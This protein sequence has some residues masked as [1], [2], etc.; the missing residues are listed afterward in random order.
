ML[1]RFS[2]TCLLTLLLA[3]PAWADSLVDLTAAEREWLKSHPVIRLGVD[4]KWPPFEYIERGRYKGLGADYTRLISDRLGIRMEVVPDLTWSQVL[5]GSRFG[6]VDVLPAAMKTKERTRFLN[7]TEPYLNFPM[8]IISRQDQRGGR[9]LDELS[10]KKVGVVKN[11]VSHELLQTKHRSLKLVPVTTLTE[12]LEALAL[13]KVEFFVGNLASVSHA[14]QSL[15]LTN[16][17]ISGDT[18]YSFQLGMAVRDDWPE[19]ASILQKTL[20]GISDQEHRQIQKNWFTLPTAA[21]QKFRSYLKLLLVFLAVGILAFLLALVWIK[22][23]NREV[24]AIEQAENALRNSQARLLDSQR[25]AH[26]GSWELSLCDQTMFWTDEIYRILGTQ[27]G[28][29]QQTFDDLLG[30]VHPKDREQL[31]RKLAEISERGG[32]LAVQYRIVQPGG[33]LRYVELQGRKLEDGEGLTGTMQDITER[34]RIE[35]FFR[36]L[37]EEVA[38]NTGDKYFDAMAEFLARSFNCAYAMI[39]TLDLKDPGQVNTLTVFGKGRKLDNFSY[40]LDKT[41][42]AHVVS[43]RVCIYPDNVQMLFPQDEMLEELGIVSYAGI[44]LY[45]TADNCMGL[46]VLLDEK[47]MPETESMRS[48]LQISASRIG[49]EIQRQRLEKQL[50][51]TA[52]VFENTRE[53]ILIMDAERKIVTVNQG[54]IDAT[55][56]SAEEVI[57]REPREMFGA[58]HQDDSFYDMM[59][60][61]VDCSGHWHDEVWNRRKTGEVFPC[62]QSIESVKDKDGEVSQ[63][64][65]VF[66][67]ITEQKRSEERVQYLAHYDVLTDLPNRILFNDRLNHAIERASRQKHSLGVLFIDLDRFKYVNDTLGHQQGDELLKKVAERLNKSVRQIDTVAR[68]G[69]DEFTVILEEVERPEVLVTVAE[70]ILHSLNCAIDLDGHQVVVGCSI[71]LSLY[72][73]DGGCAEQLLKH[74]DTA[75]YYA[76]ENGRNTYAFYSPELSRSSYEHFRLENELRH[77]VE[78][79]H[80]LL[81]YQPQQDIGTSGITTVEALVRWQPP[82]GELVAPDKF[83]P[84]AEETGLIVPLGE[85]VLNSACAQAKQW[86]KSGLNIK[87]AVNI[88]GIQIMRSDFV[89]SVKL[90]LDSSGLP[91]HLLELEVTES[92]IMSH[93]DTVIDTLNRIRELG[94]TLSIDDFGTGYS[95]LSYLRQLP[96]DV[97]KIDRSFISDIPEDSED[98]MIAAAIIAMAQNL[99]LRVVAEGVETHQQMLFL[100]ERGCDLVQGFFIAKPMTATALER[101]IN[102]KLRELYAV[103]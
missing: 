58:R 46:V 88:S 97:L 51:M 60:W 96:I 16:L 33:E 93:I 19:L 34:K 92:Y 73:D 61:S 45:D 76:K 98:E 27:R 49:G 70:K 89:D 47:A 14:I 5:V 2:L 57:G 38:H 48:L 21:E 53:G 83:I 7:F 74:A 86:H 82:G 42:C 26:V 80:L 13:G 67:D 77:A 85:W 8:V 68:L 43:D 17:Q 30:S 99:R 22:R 52:S 18:P 36:G 102:G 40:P 1:Q 10:G 100:E 101:F 24:N 4:P 50:Q 69:G 54:F 72:P 94:V 62:L 90:A 65:S 84:L 66:T 63:Y 25:I 59:W 32:D 9:N 6:K 71:G 75:M 91:P 87:V 79:Q 15:G 12:G 29:R 78:Q 56:F 3:N 23:L 39:G 41:P 55:G 95:S 37:T 28:D 44:P 11:Y 103:S 64:I 35:L 81:Y 20:A 31:T